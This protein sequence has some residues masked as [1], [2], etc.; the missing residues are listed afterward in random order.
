MAPVSFLDVK[1]AQ[2]LLDLCAAPGGKSTQIASYMKGEGI[3]VSNEVISSRAATLSRNIERLG[4][5]NALVIS[6]SPENI[7]EV[8]SGYFDRILVD[9]PCSGEGMFRKN[10][11]AILEWSPQNVSMC[12]ARQF[13]IL[14]CAYRA[15]SLGGRLVYSTCTFSVEENEQ[16][17]AA[18]LKAHLDMKLVSVNKKCGMSNAIADR[19]AYRD[20][21]IDR[22]IR[23]WPHLAR[24][25]GHFIAVFEK[26]GN[27]RALSNH[28]KKDTHRARKIGSNAMSLYRDFEK[29]Y[30]N[31]SFDKDGLYMFGSELY[32]L[33]KD[34]PN[35]AGLK[36]IRAGLHLGSFKKE[37]FEPSHSLA[38]A[39]R[40]GEAK[41]GLNLKSASDDIGNYLS[42]QT[43]DFS[44]Y[45][46]HSSANGWYLISV[47]GVSAGWG[48]A[49]AGKITMPFFNAFVH[50]LWRA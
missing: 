9:A 30:L 28:P 14:E 36:V 3:L 50:F 49:A 12:A 21:Q 8:F 42:G 47:D 5:R 32:F 23:I 11:S 43:L 41:L 17:V 26:E 10:P 4:I 6:E 18:F 24:G 22:A 45:Q 33:P 25:E 2:R 31:I 27:A 38:M 15:L 44:K 20:L 1:P 39:L 46:S 19:S 37:R 35:I 34:M 13:S 29:Q 7:A 48:K 16:N 40:Q